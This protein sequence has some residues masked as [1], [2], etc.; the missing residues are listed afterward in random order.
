MAGTKTKKATLTTVTSIE[1]LKQY[2]NGV[3]IELPCFAEGQ[4]FVARLKRPSILGM[5]KQR[6]IPNTLL[7]RANELFVQDGTGFD[8]DEENMMEQMFDVLELM[9]HESF[10]EPTYSEIKDAG[11]ELT[12]EQMMFIFNYAQQGVKALESFRTK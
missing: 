12:D 5:V 11:I 3:L 4:T 6:K 2:S 1:E 10:V 7:V 8:P 9:A